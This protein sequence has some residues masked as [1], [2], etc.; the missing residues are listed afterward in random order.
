MN[1]I[2]IY[3]TNYCPY[4]IRA[5]DLLESKGLDYNEIRLDQNPNYKYEVM[6]NLKWRTVPIIV[7]NGKVIGGYNQLLALERSSKLDQLLN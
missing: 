3:T 5:K 2:E 7:I 6:N 1:E 4:C